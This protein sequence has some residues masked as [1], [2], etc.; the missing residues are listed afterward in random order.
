MVRS[1]F[2]GKP[3]KFKNRRLVNVSNLSTA[4]I[5]ENESAR[6]A[7]FIWYG[8]SVFN[9]TFGPDNDES[10]PF[11]GFSPYDITRSK[12]LTEARLAEIEKEYKSREV[13]FSLHDESVKKRS[14]SQGESSLKDQD[15]NSSTSTASK[16]ETNPFKKQNSKSFDTSFDKTGFHFLCDFGFSDK[17]SDSSPA[18]GVVKNLFAD[19]NVSSARRSNYGG[20][21]IVNKNY[22]SSTSNTRDR[23]NVLATN[24]NVNRKNFILPCRSARSSRVIKPNKRF[25]DKDSD[26]VR[27]GS[28]SSCNSSVTSGHDYCEDIINDPVTERSKT[29][30]TPSTSG[31]GIQLKKARLVLGPGHDDPNFTWAR[32]RDDSSTIISDVESD[33]ASSLKTVC[34]LS[35]SSTSS[36]VQ[37]IVIR[38][39]RRTKK[40]IL[41]KP[42]LNIDIPPIPEPGRKMLSGRIVC[43]VCGAARYYRFMKQARKFG[44]YSCEPCRKFISRMINASASEIGLLCSTGKGQCKFPTVLNNTVWAERKWIGKQVTN[45]RCRAC[46]LKVC[47]KSYCMPEKLKIRLNKFLPIFM[48]DPV[49]EGKRTNPKN[50]SD[51]G[52]KQKQMGKHG[53]SAAANEKKKSHRQLRFENRLRRKLLIDQKLRRKDNLS[54]HSGSSDK[55]AGDEKCSLKD[56]PSIKQ[57]DN[58]SDGSV[59]GTSVD[60]GNDDKDDDD[61][62]SRRRV[63]KRISR[64]ISRKRRCKFK[65]KAVEK[66]EE[67]DDGV[68]NE[69]AIRRTRR[70]KVKE[71]DL[72]ESKLKGTEESEEQIEKGTSKPIK[73]EVDDYEMVNVKTGSPSNMNNDIFSSE[74]NVIKEEKDLPPVACKIETDDGDDVGVKSQG[75]TPFSPVSKSNDNKN[76]KLE[77][78]DVPLVVEKK[79]R[80]R[81]KRVDCDLNLNNGSQPIAKVEE[82]TRQKRKAALNSL[83]NI[84]RVTGRITESA[85]EN[86]LI[87]A[88][89]LKKRAT[90]IAR[91]EPV[92]P[93]Q[94]KNDVNERKMGVKRKRKQKIGSGNGSS[95]P[96]G[97]S[98][99]RSSTA[100]SLQGPRVKHVCRSA[101]LV[102]GRPVATFNQ[103]P[104]KSRS[105]TN[106]FISDEA[107]KLSLLGL[108]TSSSCSKSSVELPSEQLFSSTSA[109]KL[110]TSVSS[111]VQSSLPTLPPS[112]SSLP[113]QSTFSSATGSISSSG[114]GGSSYGRI[115]QPSDGPSYKDKTTD[116][117]DLLLNSKAKPKTCARTLQDLG[118]LNCELLDGVTD[119]SEDISVSIDF[120]ESYDPEEISKTGFALI[121]SDPTFRVPSLC[122]LCGSAGVDKL[123]HCVCCCEPYHLYC[124]ESGVKDMK[125]SQWWRIDWVCP[126]CAVCTACGK[127]DGTHL[128]CNKCRKS[129][130]ID[131]LPND[132]IS[133]RAHSSDR[134]W[135]CPSCLKCKSCN[136]KSVSKFVGNLP[137]CN[138]C[139][140]LRKK[141]SFCPLCQKCYDD[142]DFD[143]KMMECGRC[144]SWVHAKCE[145]LSNEKYQV[146]SFL[147]DSVEFICRLC[148]DTPPAPWWLAVESEL[149]AGY[150]NVLKSLTKNRKACDLLKWSPKK[151]T[152]SVCMCNSLSPSNKNCILSHPPL[153]PRSDLSENF[154]TEQQE[155]SKFGISSKE[156]LT[157]KKKVKGENFSNN[158]SLFPTIQEEPSKENE[159]LQNN[160]SPSAASSN[161]SNE[162]LKPNELNLVN[163]DC[164]NIND[165][166]D[167][168]SDVSDNNCSEVKTKFNVKE[169]SVPV[170]GSTQSS[171]SSVSTPASEE[172]LVKVNDHD[173]QSLSIQSLESNKGAQFSP[174]TSQSDSGI[175][176]TD[177][178]LKA[179]SSVDDSEIITSNCTVGSEIVSSSLL[180][181]LSSS[182][183][184][185][186]QCYCYGFESLS[187]SS[188]SLLYIK[189]KVNSGGYSSLEEFHLDMQYVV[190]SVQGDKL[191][192]VYNHVLFDIF[193]WFDPKGSHSFGSNN[194]D[195]SNLKICDKANVNEK[196]EEIINDKSPD[197]Y[198]DATIALKDF[199]G[200]S[201]SYY[202]RNLNFK[203]TRVCVLCK[204]VGDGPSEEEGRL[205]YCGHNEW[206]H[207]NCALWSNEVF[208]EIDGSL[209]RVH[210]AI[211]RSRGI[212]CA[213]CGKRGASVGCC[214][215]N[216]PESYHFPCAK[217]GNCVFMEDKS[218]YC[219][220]HQNESKS[221]PLSKDSDFAITRPIYVE[222]ELERKKKRFVPHHQVKVMVGSLSVESLGEFI[223]DISDNELSII[224]CEFVCTRLYWSS[225]EP[226]RL[227]RYHIKTKILQ[228]SHE[229]SAETDDN[230]TVD[231]SL[232]DKDQPMID[233]KL[234]IDNKNGDND[235]KE[236]LNE[237][238]VFQEDFSV[239]DTEVKQVVDNIL[240]SVCINLSKEEEKAEESL[241][242]LA[243]P[244]TSADLLP[245]ELKDAIFKDLPHEIL[246]GISMQ[247]IFPK[248]M[249]FDDIEKNDS[250]CCAAEIS[251]ISH[252]SKNKKLKTGDSYC[253][254]SVKKQSEMNAK[255][256]NST[257]NKSNNFVSFTG[258]TKSPSKLFLKN[259]AT[260]DKPK[261]VVRPDINIRSVNKYDFDSSNKNDDNEK[262]KSPV[263]W[264]NSAILQVD[265]A[266]D[267]C[268]GD[269]DIGSPCSSNDADDKF[270]CNPVLYITIK[271]TNQTGSSNKPKERQNFFNSREILQVDG[272]VDSGSEYESGNDSP[273][274]RD[275]LDSD[276]Y[277][278]DYDRKSWQYISQL[279]GTSD[280]NN[281]AKNSND[282]EDEPV[283]CMRC[284]RT[285]RTA[286]SYERHLSTCN[287]DYILSCSESDSS[288]EEKTSSPINGYSPSSISESVNSNSESLNHNSDSTET[289]NNGNE[290]VESPS[291]S[292]VSAESTIAAESSNS[293]NDDTNEVSASLVEPNSDFC[294]GTEDVVEYV[295][296]TSEST[297]GIQESTCINSALYKDADSPVV[298]PDNNNFTV[299]THDND[300]GEMEMP[301]DVAVLYTPD[302]IDNCILINID[303]DSKIIE[304]NSS[305][306]T[307]YITDSGGGSCAP[308]IDNG[309]LKNV[310]MLDNRTDKKIINYNQATA[311]IHPPPHAQQP[312]LVDYQTT[313]TLI[314]QEVP[315]QQNVLPTYV[316][317]YSQ[318]ASTVQPQQNIHY[319]T[320]DS[321]DKTPQ[322]PSAVLS[323][324]YQIQSPSPAC[325]TVVPT[326]VGT[327]IQPTGVEQL[328]LNTN[329]TN[330]IDVFG[331]PATSGVYLSSPPPVY[332]NMETV[333]SNTVM[334]SSQFVSVPGSVPGMLSTYSA[335]T[336]QVFQAAKPVI[337][338]PTQSYL[339]INTSPSATT[340]LVDNSSQQINSLP[341]A[342]LN[343]LQPMKQEPDQWLT[344]QYQ[345][346][347]N[348]VERSYRI[349][350]KPAVIRNTM[351]KETNVHCVGQQKLSNAAEK[352]KVND[353]VRFKNCSKMLTTDKD[354]VLKIMQNAQ[355][356]GP[357]H[358]LSKMVDNI[359]SGV[360]TAKKVCLNSMP[361]KQ[362]PPEAKVMPQPKINAS[363]QKLNS[364]S[365]KFNKNIMINNYH[366]SKDV[367]SNTCYNNKQIIDNVINKPIN[368]VFVN[369]NKLMNNCDKSK[370][371]NCFDLKKC[372]VKPPVSSPISSS[373]NNTINSRSAPSPTVLLPQPLIDKES[374]DKF[375]KLI[376]S[377]KRKVI[378]EPVNT[379]KESSPNKFTS[380]NKVRT[381]INS[382]KKQNNAIIPA[383]FTAQMKEQFKSQLIKEL[384]KNNKKYHDNTN[385]SNVLNSANTSRVLQPTFKENKILD[386][387]KSNQGEKISVDGIGGSNN[388]KR[389][390]TDKKMNESTTNSIKKDTN[391]ERGGERI[392][393]GKQK[394]EKLKRK[395]A[396]TS[397]VTDEKLKKS[398]SSNTTG[399]NNTSSGNF[400]T[401]SK[402]PNTSPNMIF[403][404]N[405]EDGFSC[406]TPNLVDAWQKVFEAV[407]EARA[408]KKLPPLPRNPYQSVNS[409]L[410][411]LGLGNN[412]L[413][414]MIEQ[415]PGVN[416]SVRYKPT[417]HKNRHHF[418]RRESEAKENESGCARTEEY[419]NRNKYD[420]FSWLA[421][422]HRRPPKLLVTSDA[423]IVNGNRR[424]TSLNLPMA[425]RFRHLRETSKEAVGVFRS[426][427]H[428]RG[429]FCLRDIDSGEMVI[430]YAGEV[431]R[432]A[433]T[434]KREKYY[435]SKGIGCYMFRIDDN[436]VVD[437][438]MKGN[439]ARFINHSCEP[440][441]YS[442]VVDILGKKHILIFAL[443]R[444]PQGEEL[445]YD[446][447]FP[448]EEDKITCHC[449]SRK[450]RKYLN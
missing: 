428:G 55:L 209:Q 160:S 325:P 47:I 404:I 148:C 185:T 305:G 242:A 307:Y 83:A 53:N 70:R 153:L 25:L 33:D 430:E 269:S 125:P 349:K 243:D 376:S 310:Q 391:K 227:V 151:Q 434:D 409:L 437:A 355:K 302:N 300:N 318:A 249:N 147:P 313:P 82:E 61:Y 11:H 78:V 144:K 244:Q 338:I 299:I 413:K 274:P 372:D 319:I 324:A 85:V 261:A 366:F 66:G 13:A 346:H 87:V 285:Y 443:R 197:H 364:L 380:D 303:N 21:R 315:S 77:T 341:Q 301:S 121:G 190:K 416:R 166:D 343:T 206:I 431:I 367:T 389:S 1:K 44:M 169:S 450:C 19:R 167:K 18:H 161:V 418:T 421:S 133:N 247:D 39:P 24:C 429:L 236:N 182:V 67:I 127:G 141:G 368:D 226:W 280:C 187:K 73:E 268:S 60:R 41:R 51:V 251:S 320:I 65:E 155:S 7:E 407:Q 199:L 204:L 136:A 64:F 423:D 178:E 426:D 330:S 6:A 447:K 402:K 193:P 54:Q 69:S 358:Q 256:L 181:P 448:F 234:K 162:N 118:R 186:K 12:E 321:G 84:A 93:F 88:R 317:T 152:S 292:T 45:I 360:S 293:G 440:N 238:A 311:Q 417:Y 201:P 288:E 179:S 212:R 361:T 278:F 385:G 208:E 109:T 252:N 130:H 420:M 100:V 46:W 104:V 228:S 63:R 76:K 362:K 233:D 441:C 377:E 399:D 191:L 189:N 398:N 257:V 425:M 386:R 408:S 165:K 329:P 222:L 348:P 128:S 57:E 10:A 220:L 156:K 337:D 26:Q 259:S 103:S 248:L 403:E 289:A 232:D 102:L 50:V 14:S 149:K 422:R 262:I 8:L 198:E 97:A 296:Q 223:S 214:F 400:T 419:V 145:G 347:Q 94:R 392:V 350:D 203:D 157:S 9:E 340:T 35:S 414:Y 297:D 176:S 40:I 345:Q 235:S 28:P 260:N 43:V 224:P 81:R 445:T 378:V 312:Q 352:M 134:P 207:A 195:S 272:C 381:Y 112:G 23:S 146:L 255:S 142:N 373:T 331:Q 396:N 49:L 92:L 286:V 4:S 90:A 2:P 218:I 433:L 15:S 123:V 328:V 353:P 205:L 200:L 71:S 138:A 438:T 374:E 183:L 143:T 194:S 332:M 202:Y 150:L 323:N 282:S 309:H 284:H 339:V 38:R 217:V 48:R 107:V 111:S 119:Q 271:D 365:D 29:T 382:K 412:S 245:P 59:A 264:K 36:S 354:D 351:R 80:G 62:K 410:K 335:T 117:E 211:S 415:L 154:D 395:E 174:H 89:N 322:Y 184:P 394:P 129:Y 34:S 20:G 120:W 359:H 446:Y 140:K 113:F 231:H 287:A 230:F 333:V 295:V 124:L 31:S 334:S 387:M 401:L 294:Q 397:L 135:V 267:Y 122:F 170:K 172:L 229:Y 3:S 406:C 96:Q 424:A 275:G 131:C 139:F 327:I 116:K 158:S 439:A 98:S 91:R 383:E 56:Q 444:I 254:N 393:N 52:K 266:T 188:P 270:I 281:I 210:S 449:L 22:L 237:N 308:V 411:M 356:I 114:A 258:S 42:R 168:I 32:S 132:R 435:T 239:I 371:E 363:L 277:Y 388:M 79:S 159:C 375:D 298:N 221:K 108:D 75:N 163:M 164:S 68:K 253:G 225:V 99:N 105:N 263:D 72:D 336:T 196:E 432:S 95:F 283:K 137:L 379:V 16:R 74:S 30:S 369:T 177:D 246:D 5:Q 442:R 326:V 171:E 314:I 215:R 306:T 405:S 216:C 115:R 175:G 370:S 106:E 192:D 250:D 390:K 342:T 279:D 436:F 219:N 357:V 240:E 58:K 427:I 101:S 344:F 316:D 110:D 213:F 265:G 180:S 241:G 173:Q 37:P 304:D 290:T 126:R 86:Q 291:S 273:R 27:S 276:S 17:V 384:N